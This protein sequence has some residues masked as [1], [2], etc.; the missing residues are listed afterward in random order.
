MSFKHSIDAITLA[1]LAWVKPI[2]TNVKIGRI[3]EPSV[4][5]KWDKVEDDKTVGYKIYWR[6]TTAP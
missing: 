4:N 6:L 5:L 1:S 3:V 2:L